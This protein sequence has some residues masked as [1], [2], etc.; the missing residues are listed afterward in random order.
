MTVY[1]WGYCALSIISAICLIVS[2][3]IPDTTPITQIS[4]L[5]QSVG[6]GWVCGYAM[7]ADV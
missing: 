1:K 5:L 3:F 7:G 2:F 4:L 6:F